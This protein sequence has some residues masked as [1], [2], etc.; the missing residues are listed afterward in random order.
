MKISLMEAKPFLNRQLCSFLLAALPF[1]CLQSE[2]IPIEDFFSD[3]EL[4]QFRISPDGSKL[5]AKGIWNGK[6]NLFVI[7][8]ETREPKRVTTQKKHSVQNYF[9]ANN[10]RLVFDLNYK[11]KGTQGLFAV[12]ADGKNFAVLV[13]PFLA[14]GNF[15]YRYNLALDRFEHNDDEI[16]VTSNDHSLLEFP[17]VYR[18][19]VYTGKKT[20]IVDNPGNIRFWYTDWNGD[21]RLGRAES[22][23]GLVRYYYRDSSDDLWDEIASFEFGDPQWKPASSSGNNSVFNYD[24]T[25][26]Y[27][28]SDIGRNTAGI[29]AYDLSTSKLGEPIF[30]DDT[31]DVGSVIQSNHRKGLIGISYDAAKPKEIYFDEERQ[32]LQAFLKAKFPDMASVIVRSNFDET[33]FVVASYSDRVEAMYSLVTIAEGRLDFELLSAAQKINPERLSKV[34]PISYVA[35]DGLRIHGYLTLP[36]GRDP[37]NLPLIVHPHGGPWARDSWGFNPELQ[38]LANRG[39]AVLQMNFRGSEGYGRRHLRAGDKTWGTDMQTD[40]VDGVKWAI[41]QGYVDPDRV[42]IYGSSYGGYATMAQLVYFPELYKFGICNVGPVDL[43]TAINWRKQ[44]EQDFVYEFYTRTIGDPKTER[45]LLEKFSPINYLENLQAPLMIVHGTLDFRVPIDQAKM[46]RKRLD[47]LGKEY[48]WLVKK[49][50]GHGF[51][52]EVSK[53]A[54]YE[55][56]DKFLA[57]FRDPSN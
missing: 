22:D 35:R 45:D 49:D 40:I 26:L 55:E 42:G 4:S 1:A 36:N 52:K 46:L 50:E 43:V 11:E 37:E 30:V 3:R 33:R 17:N 5:S 34:E 12:D 18:M 6:M 48:V 47:Q 25:Q 13:K 10:E 29:F 39:F 54:K 9:W 23:E 16:L 41:D 32:S 53:F 8:L 19:N 38:F 14:S 21:V 28:S 15:R 31:Y 2:E 7:D 20:L 27:V 44:T 56:M 57:P 24:G 51:R